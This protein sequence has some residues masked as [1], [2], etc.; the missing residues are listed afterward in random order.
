MFRATHALAA[1]GTEIL[2]SFDGVDKEEKDADLFG[3]S[4]GLHPPSTS[5]VRCIFLVFLCLLLGCV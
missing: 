2:V 4:L 5:V 3:K 1:A